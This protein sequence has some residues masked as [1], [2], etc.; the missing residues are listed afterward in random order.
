[1]GSN[2]GDRSENIRQALERLQASGDVAVV[3]SSQL[4]ETAPVDYLTQPDFLNSVVEVET[5]LNPTELLRR[6]RAVER[7][8]PQERAIAGGPRLLDIDI[9]AFEEQRSD[10]PELQLPHPRM[11]RRKFVLIPL[12]E[13][14][15]DAYC[16]KDARPFAECLRLISDPS[17]EVRPYHG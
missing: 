7:S 10:T 15:P 5:S 4:Y 11:C 14:A 2:L 3:C 6:T 13:I 12:L 17:Q 8:F 9:L 16:H 1:L